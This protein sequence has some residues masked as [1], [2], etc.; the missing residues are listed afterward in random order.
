MFTEVSKGEYIH[1]FTSLEIA[2]SKR[3]KKYIFDQ[4]FF[5]DLLCS[6]AINKIYLVKEW[7]KN[8][9]AMYTEIDKV[10][11]RIPYQVS[12]LGVSA[13]LTKNVRSQAVQKARFLPNYYLLQTS[14]D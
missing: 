10:Q 6:L 14:L 4:S 12:L 13:T 2:I 9:H 3:F 11:K 8:F 7:D 5:T 1:V